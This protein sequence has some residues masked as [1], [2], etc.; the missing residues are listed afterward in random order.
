[1]VH[2]QQVADNVGYFESVAI[3]ENFR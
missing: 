2:E 3:S 1:M